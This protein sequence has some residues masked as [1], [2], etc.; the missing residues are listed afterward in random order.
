MPDFCIGQSRGQRS[1]PRTRVRARESGTQNIRIHPLADA[2]SATLRFSRERRSGHGAPRF[3]ERLASS[4]TRAPLA[5]FLHRNAVLA[6]SQRPGSQT[7]RRSR[8]LLGAL[9][10]YPQIFK[11]ALLSQTPATRTAK[12]ITFPEMNFPVSVR[13]IPPLSPIE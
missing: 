10:T 7:A 11:H 5:Q 13:L 1:S 8:R 9:L 12:Q 4:K 3:Y 6:G 2:P